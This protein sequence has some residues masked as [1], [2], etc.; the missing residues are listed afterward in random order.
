M[1]NIT[2]HNLFAKDVLTKSKKT[3]T[4]TFIQKQNIYELFAQGFD[5]MFFGFALL[6]SNN[7]ANYC[8]THKTDTF[9]L[10]FIKEIKVQKQT[11][12]PK[13]L[14]ALYGHLTHY[15]LDSTAHPFIIYKSGEYNP[16]KPETRKYN[17]KHTQLEM[18]ID[19]YMYEQRYNKPF[20]KFKIHKHLI[21]KEKFGSELLNILNETYDK[22]YSKKHIGKKYQRGCQ[23]MYYSYKFLITDATGLKKKLYKLIDQLFPHKFNKYEYFSSHIT[24][25]DKKILNMEHKEW[26]NPWDNNKKST[27]SFLDLYEKATKEAI[28]LF[29]AT[30]KF[31]KDEITPKEYQK[32]LQDKAYT[33]GL[34]WHL[35]KEMKYLEF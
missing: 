1:P 5:P 30:H 26:T 9:F 11:H 28:K 4:N 31:L 24:T 25:I 33:T 15:I 27:Q 16:K 29:N 12:N 32:V 22:T 3:I 23:N 14:A 18:Q 10:N 20:C 2:T 13:V 19:A 21:T 8:H 35:K 34:S 7:F 17:G 6:K